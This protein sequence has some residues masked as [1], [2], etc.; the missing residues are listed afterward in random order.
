MSL[1]CDCGDD[2]Y[3]E[4]YQSTMRKARKEHRCCECG[5]AI[6]PGDIYEYTVIVFEGDFSTK[7]TCEKCSDL[8]ESLSDLGFCWEEGDLATAYREYLEQYTKSVRYDEDGVQIYPSNHLIDE[9]GFK[10]QRQCSTC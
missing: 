9:S 10:R 8:A 6:K 3:A 4:L 1:A 2:G 7:K 5:N